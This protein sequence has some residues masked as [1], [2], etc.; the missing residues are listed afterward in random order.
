MSS[1][2]SKQKKES[3]PRV[4]TIIWKKSP[5]VKSSVQI[6]IQAGLQTTPGPFVFPLLQKRFLPSR[7][8]SSVSGWFLERAERT[9]SLSSASSCSAVCILWA[10]HCKQWHIPKSAFSILTMTESRDTLLMVSQ[11]LYCFILRHWLRLADQN[12]LLLFGGSSVTPR[13]RILLGWL[14][15]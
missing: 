5:T 14:D 15:S 3:L 12:L 11:G 10:Q 2:C 8:F 13:M 7:A 4:Q 9:H 6:N 1:I